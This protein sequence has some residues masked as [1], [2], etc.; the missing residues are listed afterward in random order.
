MQVLIA[1]LRSTGEYHLRVDSTK[2]EVTD[3]PLPTGSK[4]E[5]L[6]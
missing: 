6:A 3:E 2:A 1:V 5:L 4:V